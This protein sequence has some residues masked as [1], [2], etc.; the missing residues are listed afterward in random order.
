MTHKL[1]R[2]LI[3]CF[4]VVLL[5][6]AILVGAMFTVLFSMHSA[7]IYAEDL[8]AHAVSIADTI[9]RFYQAAAD[10]GP[11]FASF[12]MSPGVKSGWPM[13]S[14]S[15]RSSRRRLLPP[16]SPPCRRGAATSFRRSLPRTGSACWI[17]AFPR[18]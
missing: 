13:R 15:P 11:I 9:A 7:A 16:F 14:F 2:R 1:T 12:R 4:S 6:F 3:L 5:L 18:T 17:P 8:E 10:S